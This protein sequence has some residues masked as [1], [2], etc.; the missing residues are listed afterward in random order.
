MGSLGETMFSRYPPYKAAQNSRSVITPS[1]TEVSELPQ[2]RGPNDWISMTTR[3]RV[4]LEDARQLLSGCVT[5]FAAEQLRHA[6]NDPTKVVVPGLDEFDYSQNSRAACLCINHNPQG[7]PVSADNS[8][9][10][11]TYPFPLQTGFTGPSRFCA[12]E[13]GEIAFIEEGLGTR[14]ILWIHGLPL[15]SR[16]WAAQRQHFAQGY[17]NIYLDLR[18]Y[19]LSSKLPPTAHDVTQLYCD[20]I[21]ALMNHLEL[22]HV[23]VV[24]FASGGHVALRFAA[25]HP[26]RIEK[27]VALNA[28][29]R[30]KCSEDFPFGFSDEDVARFTSAADGRGIE[31]LTDMVLDPN[32]VFRDLSMSDVE[33]VRSWFRTMSLNAGVDTLRGFFEHIVH[34]DDRHLMPCIAAPTLLISGSLGKEVPSQS[35]LWLRS[36][37]PRSRLA[38][39]PDADHFAFVTRPVVV[40]GLIDGFLD[41]AS[42]KG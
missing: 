16:S 22:P 5:D 1:T 6:G 11:S 41:R 33:K 42:A 40:N 23:S 35:A 32:L 8:M 20:D 21:L 17:R 31:G 26:S 9:V 30:F 38:E 36:Q 27:L 18:G 7:V 12:V 25:Q 13:G 24:G 10:L 19:G 2:I 14:P 37:I 39:V 4:V 34:D 15:D 29:A 28:S 3:M